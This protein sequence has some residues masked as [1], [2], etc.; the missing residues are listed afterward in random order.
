MIKRKQNFRC[1][2]F[3]DENT[4]RYRSEFSQVSSPVQKRFSTA[5]STSF[6]K[7]YSVVIRTFVNKSLVTDRTCNEIRLSARMGKRGIDA[8]S[9]NG[10][11]IVRHGLYFET[12][13]VGPKQI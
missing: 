13:N 5:G 4:S 10:S 7:G 1:V 3:N 8:A 11:S 9:D 12:S 2:K 6:V